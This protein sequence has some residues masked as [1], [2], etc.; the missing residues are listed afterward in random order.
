MR[1]Y[2]P[3]LTLPL[4]L[5]VS[6]MM[7]A[8]GGGD[9][10]SGGITMPDVM[11]EPVIQEPEMPDIQVPQS[12]PVAV[13]VSCGISFCGID[14]GNPPDRGAKAA[15]YRNTEDDFS[16]AM[17]V[18][19][20]DSALFFDGDVQSDTT[21]FYWVVFENMD[22]QR[23]PISAV[24]TDDTGVDP[25][26]VHAEI[27]EDVLDS[28]LVQEL[29][30]PITT[31]DFITEEIE[32]IH[33]YIDELLDTSELPSSMGS[34]A[35]SG[36]AIWVG[37]LSGYT[38]DHDIVHGGAQVVVNLGTSTGQAAFTNLESW[39]A[40]QSAGPVGT[41]TMWGDGDLAYAIALMGKTFRQTG[42]D[43]GILTGVFHGDSYTDVEG[44]LVR[45]DLEAV[46]GGT[47]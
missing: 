39:P 43:E 5:L 1:S 12:Q 16:T 42:G 26:T 11:T 29:E 33:S 18:G 27:L 14:W 24:A 31:P 9:D 36:T 47:D 6:F 40:G 20:S 28:P 7:T 37:S 21:Y 10:K 38:P 44:T 13:D 41:G 8:C 15:I 32:R 3:A 30:S 35:I 2:R 22:G 46:F 34:A 4:V 25:E 17:R 23:G 45:D 19:Q